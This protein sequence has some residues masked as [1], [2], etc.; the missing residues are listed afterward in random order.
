MGIRGAPLVSYFKTISLCP[1]ASTS[2]HIAARSPSARSSPSMWSS[3]TDRSPR[4]LCRQRE[5]RPRYRV[6]NLLPAARVLDPEEEVQGHGIR[7][8]ECQCGQRHCCLTRREAWRGWGPT[9]SGRGYHVHRCPI[10]KRVARKTE[11][12]CRCSAVPLRRSVGCPMDRPRGGGGGGGGLDH[13]MP[14]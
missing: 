1:F 4:S 11:T 13:W 9:R 5:R 6:P 14:C 7:V 8:H 2:L 10:Q 12:D 3:S